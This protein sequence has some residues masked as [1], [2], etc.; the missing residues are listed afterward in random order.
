MARGDTVG[1][2]HTKLTRE[3]LLGEHENPEL[4]AE[5]I[6]WRI[7]KMLIEPLQLDNAEYIELFNKA[8][9][10]HSN[11]EEREIKEQIDKLSS[12][13]RDNPALKKELMA[14]LK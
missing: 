6:Y 3:M 12:K 1:K 14:K 7:Q 13:V 9:A 2:L 10:W 4:N 5:F 11:A 8:W